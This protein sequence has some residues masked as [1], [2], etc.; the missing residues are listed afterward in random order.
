M[1]GRQ[2]S[3]GCYVIRSAPGRRL[4]EGGAHPMPS[5]RRF[6]RIAGFVILLQAG[7]L[8]GCMPVALLSALLGGGGGGIGGA[9]APGPQNPPAGYKAGKSAFPDPSVEAGWLALIADTP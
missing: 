7:C 3:S 4:I 1:R 6:P 2:P 9:P 8:A 5:R